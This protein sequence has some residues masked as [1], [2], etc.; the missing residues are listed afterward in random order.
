MPTPIPPRDIADDD[1]LEPVSY[2]TLEQRRGGETRLGGQPMPKL[3]AS[4]PWSGDPVPAEPLVDRSE[5]SDTFG[6]A[7]DQQDGDFIIQQSTDE[8][9]E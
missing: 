7:I 4:S 6:R 5:D 3:P 1:P 9:D 8:G 2:F